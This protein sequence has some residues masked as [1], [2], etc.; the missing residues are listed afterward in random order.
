[1]KFQVTPEQ[2]AQAEREVLQRRV[3]D[4]G[5]AFAQVFGEQVA[6]RLA[7]EAVA[8]GQLLRR[9][10]GRGRRRPASWRARRRGTPPS[11]AAAGK[12]AGWCGETRR[13]ACGSDASAPGSRGHVPMPGRKTWPLPSKPSPASTTVWDTKGH[14]IRRNG[15]RNGVRATRRNRRS[16]P[17]PAGCLTSAPQLTCDNSA[18]GG[19]RTPD[20]LVRSQVL[21]P[22]SYRRILLFR[23]QML[24]P[25]SYERSRTRHSLRHC[26]KASRTPRRGR[27]LGRS[28]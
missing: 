5:L 10:A 20:P 4:R 8:A 19:T 25:L 6:D 23:S 1:M 21:Y 17:D 15:R 9:S 26:G 28:H 16:D 13:L 22:L 2:L 7:F 24:C 3:V 27:N 14:R 12:T 11:C 18:P